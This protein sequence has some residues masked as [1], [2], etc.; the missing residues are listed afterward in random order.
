MKD[1]FTQI[2]CGIVQN[3]AN[4]SIISELLEQN[5]KIIEFPTLKTECILINKASQKIIEGIQDF[6]WLIFT[7]VL[8]VDYFL[9]IFEKLEFEMFSLDNFRVCSLGESVSDRLRFD[10]IHSD[11][12]PS[13]L[14]ADK[15]FDD[16]SNYIFDKDEFGQTKF[17]I[18]KGD[19]KENE[20]TEL[21]KNEKAFA[22]E[23][24]VYKYLKQNTADL[25]KLKTLLIG[26]AIDEFVFTSPIDLLNLKH[27]YEIDFRE[28]FAEI[29]V[30]ASDEITLRFLIEN[31]FKPKL[32]I[33]KK[34]G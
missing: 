11:V 34:R 20:I 21:L 17:L 28:L 33:Q 9:E 27:I 23:F 32:F 29:E 31:G 7:D 1:Q 12:I 16:I 6:D 25:P 2:T 13:R 26:G 5:R 14:T 15:I 18:L 30:L 22:E 8:S 10:Q 24:T 19:S 3:S 4:K